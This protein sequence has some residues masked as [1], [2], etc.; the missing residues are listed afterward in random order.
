MQTHEYLA[1]IISELETAPGLLKDG[2]AEPLVEALL[3]AKR[4]FCAGAGRSGFMMR[5]LAMRLMHAGQQ[6]YV[7]GETTTPGIGAGDLLLIGS[8]SGETAGLAAMANKAKA[9]GASVALLTTAP[10]SR[11][12][13]MADIAIQLPGAPKDNNDSSSVTIQPMGSLFEQSL[14]LCGDALI[15]RIMELTHQTG[16]GMYGMHANLE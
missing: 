2:A 8:G 9:L 3:G 12:G 4:I 13:E 6:A 5:S 10:N 1:H 11:I 16:Q 14:L 7:V 15:L